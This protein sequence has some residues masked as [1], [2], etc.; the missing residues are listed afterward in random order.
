MV[1]HFPT[2][3]GILL[4]MCPIA[5]SAQTAPAAG[6]RAEMVQAYEEVGA[7]TGLMYGVRIGYDFALAPNV[8]LGPEGEASNST[9]ETS[10][11]SLV[12]TDFLV[13][14]E[15][16][17]GRTLYAGGRIA[18]VVHPRVSIYG[19]AGYVNRRLSGRIS[20]DRLAPSGATTL[21][22]S[23]RFQSFHDG[24]RVGVGT[25]AGLM[26]SLYGGIEYRFDTY[27]GL[28][29]SHQTALTLGLRF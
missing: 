14:S 1:R 4:A 6:P 27:R 11:T 28:P 29:D 24:L 9:L 8:L 13:T 16:A 5:A 26:G 18:L 19:R 23:Q 22:A 17:F 25:Q 7:E 15:T 10:A 20:I 3:T 12:E 21:V 2:A